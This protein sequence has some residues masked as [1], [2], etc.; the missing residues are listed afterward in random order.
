MAQS[1][2]LDAV[3]S[4][5]RTSSQK[6]PESLNLKE[7]L[8]GLEGMRN[9]SQLVKKVLQRGNLTPVQGKKTDPAHPAIHPTGTKHTKR[10]TP[11]EKKLYDLIVRRFLAL[12]GDPAEKEHLRA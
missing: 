1:L 8:N 12:F 9:Y 2:Y 3:I 4:Y 6:I 7:I 11:S 5:P 10:L